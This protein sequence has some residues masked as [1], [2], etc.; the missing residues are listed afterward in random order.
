M[1]L[2]LP[3]DLLLETLG[4]PYLTFQYTKGE[5][6]SILTTRPPPLAIAAG[7]KEDLSI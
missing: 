1:G 4:T 7:E 6:T 5:A 2:P 3:Y